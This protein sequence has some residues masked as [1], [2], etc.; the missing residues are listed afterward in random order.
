MA[1]R[2]YTLTFKIVRH[3]EVKLFLEST[4]GRATAELYAIRLPCDSEIEL[5]RKSSQVA[6][7]KVIWSICGDK[8]YDHFFRGPAPLVA[9]SALAERAISSPGLYVRDGQR[10]AFELKAGSA[11][12]RVGDELRIKLPTLVDI[13]EHPPRRKRLVDWLSR[14][15]EVDV[16]S[17]VEFQ[18]LRVTEDKIFRL[19]G[20]DRARRFFARHR[21]KSLQEQLRLAKKWASDAKRRRAQAHSRRS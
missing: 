21:Q 4:S 8:S 11:G 9:K 6:S 5:W 14:L 17:A 20:D 19:L 2:V 3:E 16:K 15:T 10:L 18:R 12:L 7:A 1:K 13:T